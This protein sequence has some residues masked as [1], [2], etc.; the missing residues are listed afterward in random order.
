[1]SVIVFEHCPVTNDPTRPTQQN[2][3]KSGCKRA[4]TLLPDAARLTTINTKLKYAY[5]DH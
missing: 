5:A 3:K 4:H 2:Q 1:M